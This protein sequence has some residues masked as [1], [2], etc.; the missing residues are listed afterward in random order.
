MSPLIPDEY[1]AL[2]DSV[3]SLCDKKIAPFAK[4]NLQKLTWLA[5]QVE[6]VQMKEDEVIF[7]M[8]QPGLG[9]YQI[10]ETVYQGY[11]YAAS[12]A[13]ATVVY[14]NQQNQKLVLKNI[15]GDFVSTQPIYGINNSINYR[16]TSYNIAP[17]K[18][19]QIDAYV[20]VDSSDTIATVDSTISVDNTDKITTTIN[21]N[22]N[23]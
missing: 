4:L 14:W 6:E 2:R 13:Q 7:N 23:V 19:A 18:Y 17:S 1:D 8:A 10:G 11:T 22:S 20:D 12:T 15:N 5:S 16:F 21:E 3:R 9:N